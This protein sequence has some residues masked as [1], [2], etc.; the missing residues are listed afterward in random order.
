MKMLWEVRKYSK[1]KFSRTG[2]IIITADNSR[3]AR[4]LISISRKIPMKEL[5]PAVCIGVAP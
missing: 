4:K 2:V 5:A 1:R 3:Q